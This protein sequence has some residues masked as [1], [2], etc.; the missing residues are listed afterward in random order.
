MSFA[1]TLKH[2]R[3]GGLKKYWH[4]LHN[5]GDAKSGTLVGEDRNGNKYYENLDEIPGRH[6]WVD[7]AQNNPNSSQVDPSWHGWLAHIRKDPPTN[8]AVLIQS[9]PSW[10]SPPGENLT[11]TRGAFKTYSTT[12]PKIIA[13]EGKPAPRN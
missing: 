12:A 1:R 7:F 8:D 6:R 3:A 4:D 11:G 13:W 10:L 9:T 5:I 2:I